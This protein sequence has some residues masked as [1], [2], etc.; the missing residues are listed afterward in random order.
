M[1]LSRRDWLL[2]LPLC[3]VVFFFRLGRLG[4]IDPD[5]PFYALTAREMLARH[6]W[7]VPHIFGQPQFEKPIFFYWLA[8]AS[9]TLF[10]QNETAARLPA[11]GFASLLVAITAAFGARM[12]GRRAGLLAG[13]VLAT[14]LAL[15][16]TTRVMLTDV[17]FG[18]FVVA[19]C[20]RFYLAAEDPSRAPRQVVLGLVTTAL[21]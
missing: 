16:G 19:S 20:F 14:S 10:G 6:D 18:C 2:V 8:A 15:A 3:A 12:W 11:A 21:A 17:V 4:L 7:L 1:R 13:I 9:F 5:E